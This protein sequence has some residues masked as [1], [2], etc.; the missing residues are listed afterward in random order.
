MNGN[1]QNNSAEQEIRKNME[2][3]KDIETCLVAHITLD[4]LSVR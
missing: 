2:F 1:Q 4:L 3:V